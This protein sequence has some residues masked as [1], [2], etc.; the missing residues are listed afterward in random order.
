MFERK[1]IKTKAQNQRKACRG[2]SKFP[3][4][5]SENQN[6][7]CRG[8]NRST[9]TRYEYQSKR[10][11]RDVYHKSDLQPKIQEVLILLLDSTIYYPKC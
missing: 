8:R 3:K 7:T 1:S 10:K 11:F 6:R 4:T 5:K 2:V 9:K